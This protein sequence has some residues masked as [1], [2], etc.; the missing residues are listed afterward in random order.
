MAN[1]ELRCYNNPVNFRP[2]LVCQNLERKEIEYYTGYD[3]YH[4]A[5]PIYKKA[6]AFYC[7]AKDMLLLH[8]KTEYFTGRGQIDTVMLNDVETE[9]F[10]MP[11]TCEIYD[12]ENKFITELLKGLK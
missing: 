8:P 6:Q 9:Q 4:G 10:K 7:K 5:E 1:H 2:C 3:T 11:L 12:K